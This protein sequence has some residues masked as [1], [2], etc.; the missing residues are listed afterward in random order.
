MNIAL[1]SVLFIYLRINVRFLRLIHEYEKNPCIYDTRFC[2]DVR[3]NL[4][5]FAYPSRVEATRK[6]LAKQSKF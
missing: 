1:L 2:R 6:Y 3:A 4:N 5:M